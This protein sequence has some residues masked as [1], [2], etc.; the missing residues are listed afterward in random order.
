MRQRGSA[1]ARSRSA[2][3]MWAS[4]GRRAG[5]GVAVLVAVALAASSL[6]ALVAHPEPA[7]AVLAAGSLVVPPPGSMA[8]TGDSL[9]VGFATGSG[10]C[11]AFVACPEYSW[12]TGT[13][14]DSHYQR[15]LAL[16]PALAGNA[17]GAAAP[18]AT[19]SAFAAQVGTIAASQPDYVTVLFG[20]NDICFAST[21]AAEFA[22]QFRAGMDALFS[23]SP[24]SRVLVASIPNL[25]SIRVAVL[26]ANPAATWPLC[27]TF[28][29]ASSPSRSILM[30]RVNEYNA[31]LEAECATYANCLFDS[32]ALFDHVWSR[33]EVSTADNLHPSAAGQ[34]MMSDV[35][36]D[37]G[38]EWGNPVITPAIGVV[39]EGDSA[40]PTLSVPVSLSTSSPSTVTAHYQ[41]LDI[42]ANAPGDYVSTAGTVT[43]APGETSKTVDI[44]IVGDTAIEPNEAFLVSFSAPTNA[45]I[46]GFYGLGVGLITDDD[47]GPV[48]TNWTAAEQPRVVQSAAYLSQ[49][50]DQLQKTGVQLISYLL[51][52]SHPRP[53]RTPIVPPPDTSGPVAYTGT[54]TAGDVGFLRTVEAQYTLNAEQAQKLGVQLVNYLLAISGH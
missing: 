32:N 5:I 27:G 30:G 18:G 11:G 48:T 10:S 53:P 47:V 31:V 7:E 49:S 51:A 15:L 45:T 21:T 29:N 13:A 16:N 3:E 41:T 39:A 35:L 9:S 24:D 54:W 50:P 36:Y 20:G 25:E 34:Q 14:V 22:T 28:F 19:M 52:I 37:A 46:G 4:R 43:F 2:P 6:G 38:Y 33:D 44:P 23:A 12:S 40:T 42:T 26:A 8:A 17:T 1:S